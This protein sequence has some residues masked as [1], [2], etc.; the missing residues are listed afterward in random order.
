[1]SCPI[2]KIESTLTYLITKPRLSG[3]PPELIPPQ[4]KF[5]I[6]KPPDN[7]VGPQFVVTYR[8]P[9]PICSLL[10]P[11]LP[12]P[13]PAPSPPRFPQ[14]LLACLKI[15]S[16]NVPSR[17]QQPPMLDFHFGVDLRFEQTWNLRELRIGDLSST[18]S[19]APSEQLTLE[20]H[21]SQRTVL[22]KNILDSTEEITS[23]E[24]TTSDKEVVN[25]A[26]SSS[27]TQNWHVDGSGTIT[28]PV[29]DIPLGID[30][31]GGISE[32]ITQN[33]QNSM[34]QITEATRKSAHT[35][36]TLH[37]IEVRGVTE[38]LIQSRMTRILQNPYRDRT[39]SINVF[40]LIKRFSVQTS[41]A[42]IRPLLIFKIKAFEF[43]KDFIIQNSDFLRDKLMDQALVGE[44]PAILQAT[45][46][47]DDQ[48]DAIK[49]ARLALR[50]LYD[51][52]NIFNFAG[53]GLPG[54]A[55]IDLPG[56]TFDSNTVVGRGENPEV[57]G[58]L[59]SLRNNMLI[60][61][62]TLAF[63]YRIYKEMDNETLDAFAVPMASALEKALTP[64][65]KLTETNKT[66]FKALEPLTY[67]EVMKRLN[68]FLAM[69]KYMLTPLL[70]VE[71]S[72]VDKKEAALQA[73]NASN[74]LVHH[75][76]CHQ[77]YYIQQYLFYISQKTNNQAIIDFVNNVIDLTPGINIPPVKI[78]TLLR[79]VLN[80]GRSYIDGQQII[81]P[82]FRTL[83][84]D[85]ILQLPLV[86]PN[87]PPFDFNKIKP[88]I[89][90]EIDVPSDGVHLEVAA[91]K[92]IL[93]D[94]PKAEKSVELT[95][96]DA[97]LKVKSD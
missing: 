8:R 86:D 22:E 25:V 59:R 28:I 7:A 20:F 95:V 2:D 33:S 52:P 34:E 57:T 80:I 91:G 60:P 81:V 85:D 65:W 17:V 69:I 39:L 46:S 67:T 71:E 27:K 55:D 38:G 35:L 49:V 90:K 41:L 42:D 62:T 1:M 32:N 16:S 68:G 29:G 78:P 75:L 15:E 5:D 97:N 66:D 3:A 94:L 88:I 24:S 84:K 82:G 63:F 77:N 83:D 89:D 74:R 48:K 64:L 13:P 50:Y 51:V 47:V 96:K 26:R 23:A 58:Y 37:K 14:Y 40:Q 87:K 76:N 43:D 79:L 93:K 30:I 56:F 73:A 36:K 18:I 70:G 9:L 31:G 10:L 72:G 92:C 19:L 11:A 53:G 45:R 54:G 21:T 6:C 4:K 44:L 12:P 61:F